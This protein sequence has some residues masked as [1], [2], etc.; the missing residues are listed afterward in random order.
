MAVMRPMHRQ[1][2]NS[3]VAARG[4][5]HD[6]LLDLEDAVQPE[7]HRRF[8]RDAVCLVYRHVPR[9]FRNSQV[10]EEASGQRNTARWLAPEDSLMPESNLIRQRSPGQAKIHVL[11]LTLDKHTQGSGGRGKPKAEEPGWW[12]ANLPSEP[13]RPITKMHPKCPG[14]KTLAGLRSRHTPL[15]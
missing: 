5:H 3:H 9:G 12:L 8:H 14:A 6:R 4:R 7:Y 1:L 13:V 10:R 2:C 15:L 11:A